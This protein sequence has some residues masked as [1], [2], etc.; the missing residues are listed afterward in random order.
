MINDDSTP[1]V[2]QN[3]YDIKKSKR[4]RACCADLAVITNYITAEQ[5]KKP[6]SLKI[7]VFTVFLTVGVVTMLQSVMSITPILFVQMGQNEAGAIDFRL[8]YAL[9]NYLEGD[10]DWYNVNPFDYNATANKVSYSPLDTN[11]APLTEEPN[12]RKTLG[13]LRQKH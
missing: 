9:S 12:E 8:T 1:L 5:A 13:Q 7:G 11:D 2:P 6:E 3:D 10:S 4:S